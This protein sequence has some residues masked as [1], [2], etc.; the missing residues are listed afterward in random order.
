MSALV[1][2]GKTA[3]AP[4]VTLRDESLDLLLSEDLAYKVV[5]HSDQ[6]GVHPDN[7]GGGSELIDVKN[8]SA[9]CDNLAKAGFSFNEVG[10]A[11]A[12]ERLAP[13]HR[14]FRPKFQMCKVRM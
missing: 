11:V 9:K 6:V 7:R 2:R 12:V 10:K 3:D 14:P 5:Y 8:V 4:M 13:I 1:Q